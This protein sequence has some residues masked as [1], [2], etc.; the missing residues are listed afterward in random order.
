MKER[1]LLT[2]VVFLAFLG[3]AYTATGAPSPMQPTSPAFIT[4]VGQASQLSLVDY[5]LRAVGISTIVHPT[6]ICCDMRNS[7]CA[8]LVFGADEEALRGAKLTERTERRRVDDII[9]RMAMCRIPRV[10]VHIGPRNEMT[11]RFL[12]AHVKGLNFLIAE[13]DPD[14]YFASLAAAAKVNLII[15]ESIDELPKAFLL[16]FPH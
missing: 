11:D 2:L 14:G 7:G 1:A 4:S 15:I 10:G 16:V 12:E 13:S 9:S 6:A 8:L 5:A 3:S